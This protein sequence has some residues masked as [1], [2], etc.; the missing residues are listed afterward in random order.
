MKVRTSSSRVYHGRQELT[1]PFHDQTIMVTGYGCLCFRGARSISVT[2]FHASSTQGQ[3][4]AV[5]MNGMDE[6]RTVR[7]DF[8][9]LPQSRDGVINRPSHRGLR[10]A[11]DL[12][13]Q[14][15]PVDDTIAAFCQISDQ[16]AFAAAE[17]H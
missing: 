10:V 8:E 3:T 2:R 17:R 12:A 16:L 7:V 9:L 6:A 15:V 11:P 4:V 5:S 14:L 13:E 1:Y